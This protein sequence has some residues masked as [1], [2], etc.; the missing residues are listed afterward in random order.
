MNQCA[1]YALTWE[2][3]SGNDPRK[4]RNNFE[5]PYVLIQGENNQE[6]IILYAFCVR[7][8][9]HVNVFD[10]L[11]VIVNIINN[12]LVLRFDLLLPLS[13]LFDRA[14]RHCHIRCMDSSIKYREWYA[15]SIVPA[16]SVAECRDRNKTAM[17]LE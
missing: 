7:F 6:N 1:N 3:R 5:I 16:N 14:G 9:I 4:R 15:G 17:S 8:R 13:V 12:A 11:I 10:L 2:A